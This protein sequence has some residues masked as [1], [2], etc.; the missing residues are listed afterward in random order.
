MQ[1][2]RSHTGVLLQ[3]GGAWFQGLF[4]SPRRGS[5]HLSLAVL[6]RYRSATC[7]QPC[8]VGPAGSCGV[9][10]VPHYSGCPW[11]AAG[12]SPRGLSPAP[13]RLSRRSGWP[14]AIRVRVLQPRAVN[15]PVW[16]PPRSLAAT[17]GISFD[18]FSRGTEMFHFPRCR[19]LRAMH[20]R[21][22]RRVGPGGVAPFGN[23]RVTGRLRLAVEYRRLPRPSSP[24]AA[25]A[26][27][28]RPKSLPAKN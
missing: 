18:F 17:C 19:L 24:S 20:S 4:H 5:F 28:M 1:K 13:A 23:P 11:D 26:S 27:A 16:A 7:I 14:A 25:K 6:V 3:S 9:S 21:A 8:G 2:A 22:D 10:R 15:R 12:P